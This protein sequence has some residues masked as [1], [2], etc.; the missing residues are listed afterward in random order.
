MGATIELSRRDPCGESDLG[1]VGETLAGVGCPTQEPPPALDQI[2][3]AG[4]DGN[5][6]LVDARVGGQPV[7]DGCARVAG[8]IVRNQIQVALRIVAVNGA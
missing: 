1:A 8:E 6:D 4:A 5:E 2:E 3:P 7:T